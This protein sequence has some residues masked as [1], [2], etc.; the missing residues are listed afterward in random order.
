MAKRKRLILDPATGSYRPL[1]W[2]GGNLKRLLDLLAT[3]VSGPTGSP[4]SYHEC[5]Y[6]RGEVQGFARE[7]MR[8]CG[9]LPAPHDA[10]V[11]EVCAAIRS[12]V[13]KQ[14]Q[15]PGNADA[16]LDAAILAYP[17]ENTAGGEVAPL[18]PGSIL[19]GSDKL[20]HFKCDGC[21]HTWK[22]TKY[23]GHGR[24]KCPKCEKRARVT[25]TLPAK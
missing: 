12:A 19:V 9:A 2:I 7:V 22:S 3:G 21:G 17:D 4:D 25:K 24:A 11:R 13:R 16:V 5:S 8:R 18:V 1:D 14:T 15:F 10:D 6:T 23:A 20:R